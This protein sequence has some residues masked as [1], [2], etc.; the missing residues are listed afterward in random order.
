VDV[1]ARH[2]LCRVPVELGTALLDPQE[3]SS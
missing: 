3:K 2:F 1:N